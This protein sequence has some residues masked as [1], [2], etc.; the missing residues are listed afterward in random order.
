MNC[1][2]MWYCSMIQLHFIMSHILYVY[3]LRASMLTHSQPCIILLS[4]SVTIQVS[5]YLYL[6]ASS[7]ISCLYHHAKTGICCFTPTKYRWGETT[8]SRQLTNHRYRHRWGHRFAQETSPPPF[9]PSLPPSLPCECRY[10]LRGCNI[11]PRA[12]TDFPGV[13]K[14]CFYGSVQIK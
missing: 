9:S 14:I 3:M 10:S 8:Q 7:C 5:L 4:P 2:V 6:L 12:S 1:D 11:P 13:E